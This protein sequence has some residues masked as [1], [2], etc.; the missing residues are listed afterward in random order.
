MNN[1]KNIVKSCFF[2]KMESKILKM[3]TVKGK[4]M[5]W[6]FANNESGLNFSAK[7]LLK[8]NTMQGCS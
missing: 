8:I 6:Q 1:G 5:S 3:A 4:K 7:N 2:L